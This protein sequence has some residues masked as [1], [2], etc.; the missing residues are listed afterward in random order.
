MRFFNLSSFKDSEREIGYKGYVKKRRLLK[1]GWYVIFLVN[2]VAIFSKEGKNDIIEG[3]VKSI[4][5]ADD[6][7]FMVIKKDKTRT[8]F[9][10]EG[11]RLSETSAMANLFFNGWFISVK[12]NNVALC[13]A[14]GKCLCP[15]I[16]I[17][18]VFNDG[19]Y[20][21]AVPSGGN[22]NDV[23]FFDADGN[24]VFFTNDKMFCRLING[25]FIADGSLFDVNGECL[26]ESNAG[27]TFNRRLVRFI[28]KIAPV[29]H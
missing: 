26:I 10:A 7:K 29:K 16:T 9:D 17:A 11:N 22:A 13:D 28:K 1:N 5:E 15:M 19:M 27:S 12:E 20:F 23:G 2:R 21:V 24:R 8:I 18:K 14:T 4:F 6:G 25:W 3:S